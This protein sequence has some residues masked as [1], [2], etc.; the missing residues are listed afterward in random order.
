MNNQQAVKNY[1]EKEIGI[2]VS[3]NLLA[4]IMNPQKLNGLN[5]SALKD[6]VVEYEPIYRRFK[7]MLDGPPVRNWLA[8]FD[9]SLMCRIAHK[10]ELEEIL[11]ISK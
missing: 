11:G 8:S 10:P 2:V 9:I 6:I 7:G 1:I 4:F 5:N 3:K